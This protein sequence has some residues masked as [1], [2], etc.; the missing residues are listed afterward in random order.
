MSGNTG[1]H[2]ITFKPVTY[3]IPGMESVPVRRDV[4]YASGRSGPLTF[5]IYHPPG[6]VS[7]QHAPVVLLIIGYPDAGP[8]RP[9]GCAF[10]EMEMWISLAQLLAASGM[11]AVTY[12]SEVPAVDIHVLINYL[13]DHAAPLRLD[14]TRIALW[15]ASG[16]VPTALATLAR[17][18]RGAIKAAVL[19]TGFTLDLE[20]STVAD[21]A[22][23]YGFANAAA[24]IPI[25]ELPG[26][27]ALFIA[28][29]G[30]DE[31]PGLNDTLDRFV[32]A[33]IGHNL[34]VT[35]MNH[36]SAG[37]AFEINDDSTLS[38]YI[39][40]QMLAFMRFWLIA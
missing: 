11:T 8:R 24:G 7:D 13:T 30:R 28:R 20:G 1:R 16:H 15:A 36:P 34:L 5:D 38:K 40:G 4:Q 9:L 39:I 17:H 12:T 26:R 29:A 2:P 37:H 27:V 31:N 33:V 10:K 21:A 3:R 6:A 14:S 23:T 25:A 18:N 22:Q 35:I 19:S 32:T